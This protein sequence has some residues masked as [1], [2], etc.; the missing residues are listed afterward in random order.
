M[1][2]TIHILIVDDEKGIREGCRRVL[3]SEGYSADT[4]ENGKVGLEMV[5]AG[6]YDLLLVDLMMPVMGGLELMEQVGWIDPEIIMIVI[7]G[8]ATIETA[9]DA[10]KHGAYDYVPKPFAPDQLVTVVN[11]GLE[12]RRLSVQAKRLMEERDQKLLEVAHEKSKIHTIVNSMADGIF[13]INMERQLVLWNP[14]AIKMLDLDEHLEPGRS[15]GEII[16]EGAFTNIITRAFTPDAGQYTTI[17]EEINLPKPD[18]RTLMVNV[19]CI[20]DEKGQELGVVSTLRDITNLKEIEQVKSQFVSMVTHELRAP[21]SAVEGYLTAYLTNAVGDDP[22][23][24][25]QM[26]ER[27]RQRTHSLLDLVGDLLQFSRLES[28]R[29]E[30]KKELLDISPIIINTMELLKNQGESKELEFKMEMPETLPLIEAD[31]SEMEQLFTNLISNAIKYN[32]KKGKVIVKAR[33]NKDFLEIKV[34]DTGIGI[35]EENLP[36]IYEEFFRVS[37]PQTRYTT[38]TGLGLSIV[39]RIVESHFGRIDVESKVGKGTTFRVKFPVK[40]GKEKATG[41]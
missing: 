35:D 19:S 7:T 33:E 10:M 23:V 38:G 40:Q 12:K 34:V 29:I 18:G 20:R 5:R 21:L 1:A 14:A 8:F 27:A 28:K 37:G 3:L 4:A 30:R 15:I 25:R 9:V 2:E 39:K 6:S 36:S 32:V 16:P 17:S 11:R 31:R 24:N 22:K 26:L 13:V 41:I